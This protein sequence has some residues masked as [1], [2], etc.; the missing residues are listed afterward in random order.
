[1]VRFTGIDLGPLEFTS[2]ECDQWWLCW[3]QNLMGFKAPPYNSV[4]VYLITKEVI[5]GNCR[6]QNNPFL[7]EGI[8]LNLPQ[9]R[10]YVPSSA[11]ITKMRTDNLLASD[12]VCFVDDQQVMARGSLQVK[13]AGH[14]EGELPWASR[15]F[16]ENPAADGSY[17]LGAWAGANVC[18]EEPEGVILLM[19]REKWNRLKSTC[20]KWL[21]HLN[22][23]ATELN[24]KELQ[25]DRGFMV[26]AT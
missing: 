4:H 18:I 22:Q 14:L 25:S 2:E 1:M 19:S 17:T 24:Y 9:T 16:A 12:F 5:R 6:E 11:W 13:E 8:M 10:E 23:N 15:C 26:Y 3:K 20:N 7:W 21:K